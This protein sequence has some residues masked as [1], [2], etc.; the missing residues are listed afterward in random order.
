MSKHTSGPWLRED[1]TVYALEH[2]G[3][4]KGVEQ[5]RNRFDARPQGYCP[6]EELLANARLIAAAPELL[7]ALIQVEELLEDGHWS[8]TKRVLRELIAKA[9][10]ETP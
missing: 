3:W 7:A 1:L 2:H 5:F 4:R 9:T 8:N 10:G 6:E